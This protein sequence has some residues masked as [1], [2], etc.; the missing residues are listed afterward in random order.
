MY[1]N[2][3]GK[4]EYKSL[5]DKKKTPRQTVIEILNF[6]SLFRIVITDF[7]SVPSLISYETNGN[8]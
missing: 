7:E 6:K 4:K 3:K 8:M 1:N 5:F 2:W